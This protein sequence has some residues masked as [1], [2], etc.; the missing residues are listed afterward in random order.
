MKKIIALVGASGSGKT[1]IGKELE[2]NGIV[3]IVSHTTRAPREGEIEGVDYYYINKETFDTLEK[4]EEVE[5]NGQFYCFSKSEVDAKLEENDTLYVVID[6]HGYEQM[7]AAY[8]DMVIGIFLY[9]S[10]EEMRKR[11]E[12]RG[13]K[14]ENIKSRIQHAIDTKELENGKYFNYQIENIDLN[15][16]V[17]SV[18]DIVKQH[19]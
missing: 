7:K 11:M 19:K 12:K 14:E 16:S 5:Y 1:T 3:Q 13:D 15:K 18:L 9:I 2:K 8:G 17:Q 10:L 6:R 4:I